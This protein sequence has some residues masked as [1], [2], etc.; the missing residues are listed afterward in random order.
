MRIAVERIVCPSCQ[1]TVGIGGFD[2]IAHGIIFK[3]GLCV[4]GIDMAQLLIKGIVSVLGGIAQR[5]DNAQQIGVVVVCVLSACARRQRFA[6]LTVERIV[7]I[8]DNTFLAV[9]FR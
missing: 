3:R 2:K 4:Q 6:H 7:S 1:I 5:I 9:G 8:S